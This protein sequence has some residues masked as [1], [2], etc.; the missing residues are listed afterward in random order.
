MGSQWI[1]RL[2]IS[3]YLKGREAETEGDFHLQGSFPQCS[4]LL[5]LSQVKARRLELNLGPPQEYQG[6]KHWSH[7]LLPPSVSNNRKQE[8]EAKGTTHTVCYDTGVGTPSGGFTT[9]QNV[10]PLKDVE[11]IGVT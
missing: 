1:L 7:Y 2:F 4:Q 10:Y 6:P 9:M 5:G 8:L 11:T 3:T